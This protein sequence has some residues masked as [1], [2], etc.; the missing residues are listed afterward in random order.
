MSTPDPFAHDPERC[1]TCS[2]GTNRLKPM[3]EAIADYLEHL[4]ETIRKARQEAP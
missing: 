3:R 2:G 1:A 4:V